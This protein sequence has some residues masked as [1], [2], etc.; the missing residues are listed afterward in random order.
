LSCEYTSLAKWNFKVRRRKRSRAFAPKRLQ[1]TSRQVS[2]DRFHSPSKEKEIVGVE[3]AGTEQLAD[4]SYFP[5]AA[6]ED[7]FAALPS[8]HGLDDTARERNAERCLNAFSV[9]GTFAPSVIVATGNRFTDWVE[10]KFPEAIWL[11]E[12]PVTA[13]RA[14]GGKWNGTLDL[15]LELSDSSLVII[16]HK[17]A[18]IRRQHCEAKAMAY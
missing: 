10:T 17:S 2:G 5:A 13:N 15:V 18:P 14:A 3:S 11:T 16:D 8:M 9:S 1:G 7:Q 6:E 12:I 4:Q